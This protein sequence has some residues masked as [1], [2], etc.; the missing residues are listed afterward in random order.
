MQ[1]NILIVIFQCNLKYPIFSMV[2]LKEL[3]FL[4]GE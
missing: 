1:L 4:K 3:N 2:I